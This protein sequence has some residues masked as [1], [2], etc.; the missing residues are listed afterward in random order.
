MSESETPD[1]ELTLRTLAM[2]A[3][4]NVNGDIF[5]GWVLSQMDIAAGMTAGA[6]AQGRVTTVA[7]DAMKFIRPV[8]VGDVLCVYTEVARVGTSSMGIH[9]EAW[10]LRNRIGARERVTEAVFTFVAIDETGRPRP[11]P[12]GDDLPERT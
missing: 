12:V 3:D 6:R 9:V 11:V 1:G 5:G 8:K 4:V 2:P 10:V 7:L